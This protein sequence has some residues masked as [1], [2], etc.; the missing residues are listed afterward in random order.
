MLMF[1][2]SQ[3]LMKYV[4]KFWE[5][6]VGNHIPFLRHRIFEIGPFSKKCIYLCEKLK[7]GK[8]FVFHIK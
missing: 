8:S 3:I 4:G 1:L 7:H 2:G 5:S 6:Q